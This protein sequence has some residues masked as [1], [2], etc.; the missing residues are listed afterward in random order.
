MALATATPYQLKDS[1]YS[2]HSLLL[3]SLP[4]SGDGRRVLDVGCAS[5][6]LGAILAG[7]GYRVT[8]IDSPGARRENFPDAIEF[9]EADLD[10]GLPRLTGRFDFVICADVLEHLRRPA[11]LLRELREVLAP[12]GRLAA[13]LPNSGHA[14][15]R[16]N[17]LTGRFPAHDRGLFDRTHLHFYTWR[18][19]VELFHECGFRIETLR[20][21]GVPIGL[22]LPKWEGSAAV[23]A[24]ERLS[25]ES[26]RGW[27]NMFAY[28]FIVTA[29]P[30]TAP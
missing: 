2:S 22:A 18:G 14:Y 19:W 8:G 20:C 16:W 17:V 27:K 5:G 21:S 15:F 3:A 9:F 7:R 12:G 11:S 6:Y 24:L 4:A 26:A 23:R 30:E 1:P 29:A 25:Y 28:Q 13:S 10:L